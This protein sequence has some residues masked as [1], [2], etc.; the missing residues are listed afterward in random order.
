MPLIRNGAS[1]YLN[2]ACEP[3]EIVTA[4]HR[5]AQG[6]RYITAVVAELL[7][8]RGIVPN[9]SVGSRYIQ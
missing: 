7:A 9:A 1:G 8:S 5:V 6:A 3:G 2:K 4:I